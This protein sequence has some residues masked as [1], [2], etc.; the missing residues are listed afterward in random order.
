MNVNKKNVLVPEATIRNIL[1]YFSNK[2]SPTQ[3]KNYCLLDTAMLKADSHLACR[4]HA[5]PMPF[6]CHAVP[7]RV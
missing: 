3:H 5:E 7:L 1:F 2:E 6:P 4:A